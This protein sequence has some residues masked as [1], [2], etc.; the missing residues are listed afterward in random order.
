MIDILS[1]SSM[2]LR[3]ANEPIVTGTAPR[4]FFNAAHASFHIGHSLAIRWHVRISIGGRNAGI[5]YLYG[6]IHTS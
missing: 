2:S 3:S 5:S 6:Y 1:D 4:D